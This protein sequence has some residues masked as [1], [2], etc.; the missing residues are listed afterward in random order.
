MSRKTVQRSPSTTPISSEI[1]SPNSFLV[2]A[3]AVP[4]RGELEAVARLLH[5][6]VTTQYRIEISDSA[7]IDGLTDILQVC[8]EYHRNLL[9]RSS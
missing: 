1:V 4:E 7:I 5:N 2:S 6:Q 9:L 3:I 8:A